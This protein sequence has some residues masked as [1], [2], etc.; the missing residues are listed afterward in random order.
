MKDFKKLCRRY[1]NGG[2]TPPA[3]PALADPKPADP[4]PADPKPADPAPADPKPADPD[5][6]PATFTKKQVDDATAAAATAAIE[7][8]IKDQA[9]AKDYDKMTPEQKVAYLESQ[10]KD[11]KLSDFARDEISKAKLPTES[12]TFL[13]GSDEADTTAKVQAF[14]TMYEAAVQAGVDERFKSKGYDVTIGT[15]ASSVPADSLE[16]AIAAELSKSL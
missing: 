13:K 6:T 11:R 10:E 5:P 8:Y 15:P 7:K 1:S 4:A 12:L 2:V 9:N 16:A 14:K 3:D